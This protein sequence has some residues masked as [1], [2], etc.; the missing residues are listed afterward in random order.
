MIRMVFLLR[1]FN[2]LSHKVENAVY[3][4]VRAFMLGVDRDLQ[5]Q[6]PVW[7]GNMKANWLPSIDI[8]IRFPI[9]DQDVIDKPNSRSR[10]LLYSPQRVWPTRAPLSKFLILSNNVK[11]AQDINIRDGNFVESII[12]RR[13][14]EMR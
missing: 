13:A 8:A 3:A 12:A 5:K 9:F 2:Q 4:K 10:P 6:T 11:Y 7:S 14:S 1:G